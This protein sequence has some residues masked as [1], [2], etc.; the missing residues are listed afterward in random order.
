VYL[1]TLAAAECFVSVSTCAM[2]AVTGFFLFFTF[3]CSFVRRIVHLSVVIVAT[4]YMPPSTSDCSHSPSA[5]VIQNLVFV[6]LPAK[7]VNIFLTD[8]I[9]CAGLTIWAKVILAKYLSAWLFAE[10]VCV[11]S[12]LR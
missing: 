7:L 4:S 10:G 11:V 12:G 6:L 3:P 9:C 5:P 1:I 2:P 8:E